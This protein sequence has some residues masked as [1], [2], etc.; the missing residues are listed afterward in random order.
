MPTFKSRISYTLAA[1][2][3]AAAC[4]TLGGYLVATAI[5]VR[6]TEVK[7][8]HYATQIVADWEASSAE[9]REVLVAMGASEHHPCSSDEIGY[10]RKLILESDYLKDAGRMRDGTIECSAALGRAVQDTQQAQPD[11][12]QQ[13]G[14]A[15]YTNLPQYRN[16]DLA[17]LTLQFGEFFVA[18][19]PY[20]RMHLEP[21]P[22]HY[23]ETAI[24]A[25]T[26]KYAR[27]L[28]EPAQASM[29]IL[30]T[31]GISKIGEGMY[32][33]QCSIR[34]FNCVTAYSS[35]SEILQANR[36]RF[37]G[38][39]V[40]CGLLGGI[41]G[42]VLALL[43]RRNKSL[44]Q[45]LRR[46]IRR[47]KLRFVY[48]PQIELTSGHIVGA[49]ALVRWTDED[50][51]AV[52]PDIFVK[53]AEER[54]FVG[55]ITKLVVRHALRDFGE[56]LRS[57]PGFR[58]SINVAAA[59]LSDREF[60]PM[61]DNALKS[62]AVKARSLAIEITEGSTARRDVATQTI[63]Q[64]RQRGHSVHIDDFGT[65]YSSLAYLHE[66]SVDAIK[67]DKAFTQAI[68]TGSVIVAI[69]PQILAMAEAL[70]LEVIVEG[71]ENQLQAEY[72]HGAGT[73][74]LAQGW[75][76][77]RPVSVS[78]FQVLLAEEDKKPDPPDPA[79]ASLDEE[80]GVEKTMSAA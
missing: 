57:H 60:L 38:C 17:V 39:I 68:G 41:G 25:P 55:Q 65:G 58:L 16:S 13:D 32:A 21:L 15:I 11:F 44:E 69:L 36:A 19:T 42:L 66:L 75:L 33:T 80:S 4:G 63:H 22:M 61:L 5:A 9:L 72:F 28:G 3:I 12:T 70:N 2:V 48:Q 27:L 20:P 64:L 35:M 62:A 74:V 78:Q 56:T 14:T 71:V 34:F 6:V 73:A 18:F 54:G 59:D 51:F 46:A 49:E 43:Y 50:G 23:T 53:I 7:L 26:Q 52:G 30:T 40:L 10:F 37:D 79:F 31:E 8:D 1:T 24:D 77:G 76:F 45:Q 67:I 47:D 29:A